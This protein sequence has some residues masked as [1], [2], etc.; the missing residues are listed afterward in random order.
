MQKPEFGVLDCLS[1][2]PDLTDM[3]VTPQPVRAECTSR[4]ENGDLPA[5]RLDPLLKLDEKRGPRGA[6]VDEYSAETQPVREQ[7]LDQDVRIWRVEGR[8]EGRT[9]RAEAGNESA[10]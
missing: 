5:K 6:A 2:A 4:S 3:D 8:E 1:G 9:Q 10:R 7:V